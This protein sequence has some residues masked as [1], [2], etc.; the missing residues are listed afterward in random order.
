[1]VT[2]DAES[3]Y[4]CT[5]VPATDKTANLTLTFDAKGNVKYSGKIG[6]KSIGGT[7]VLNI[8][9]NCMIGDL[10]VPLGKTEALYFALIFNRGISGDPEPILD[11]FHVVERVGN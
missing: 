8:D 4:T 7:S 2:G 10:A 9:G 1:M 6:G 3:G 5:E 11:I